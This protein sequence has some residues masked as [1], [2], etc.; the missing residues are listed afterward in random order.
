[1]NADFGLTE[2]DAIAESPVFMTARALARIS[3]WVGADER[4]AFLDQAQWLS[5][6]WTVENHIV[7]DRHH[8]DVIDLL[9]DPT[10]SLCAFLTGLE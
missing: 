9:S 5:D 7:P 10:S 1:M 3:V 8:F 6:A 4:P 2:H